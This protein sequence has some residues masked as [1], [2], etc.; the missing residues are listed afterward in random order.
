MEAAISEGGEPVPRLPRVWLGL[1]YEVDSNGQ[2][3]TPVQHHGA[4]VA[5]GGGEASASAAT[6]SGSMAVPPGARGMGG[7]GAI[8]R[9]FDGDGS[10][11]VAALVRQVGEGHCERV[12]ILLPN[13]SG[14]NGIFLGGIGNPLSNA[15]TC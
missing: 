1:T 11:A 6:A 14:H 13:F 4:L 3:I 8:P 2:L 10:R 15:H 12:A 7:R 9:P 5:R